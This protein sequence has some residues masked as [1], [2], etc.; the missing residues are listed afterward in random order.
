M[1]TAGGK[2]TLHSSKLVSLL[3][4]TNTKLLLKKE[5]FSFVSRANDFLKMGHKL[6]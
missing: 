4:L 2:G 5:K 6:T 1:V 3:E